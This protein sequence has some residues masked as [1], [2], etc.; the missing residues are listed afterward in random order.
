MRRRKFG[1]GILV[2]V[3]LLE[4]E[5]DCESG[6]RRPR[7]A[8]FIEMERM[9]ETP[10]DHADAGLT[11]IDGRA[12]ATINKHLDHLRPARR[13]YGEPKLDHSYWTDVG[14]PGALRKICSVIQ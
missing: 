5:A 10:A 13:V 4:S 2:P 11:R 1:L 8:T 9:L 6:H 7:A 14:S 12:Q 3:I